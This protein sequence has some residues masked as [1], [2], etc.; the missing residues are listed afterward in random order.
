MAET[1]SKGSDA[2]HETI[3]SSQ[4]KVFINSKAKKIPLLICWS[5]PIAFAVAK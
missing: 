2:M 1:L 5:I 3:M 4:E